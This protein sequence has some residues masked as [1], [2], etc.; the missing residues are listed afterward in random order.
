[1]PDLWFGRLCTI[2][3]N[4]LLQEGRANNRCKLNARPISGRALSM[5]SLLLDCISKGSHMHSS[6]AYE[7]IAMLVLDPSPTPFYNS[8]RLDY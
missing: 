3:I 7:D 6:L 5:L 8:T 2:H 1:L 4:C